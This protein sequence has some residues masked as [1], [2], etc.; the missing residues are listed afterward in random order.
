MHVKL[1]SSEIGNMYI[2]VN[3]SRY[4]Y[5]IRILYS[6]GRY[7]AYERGI[8]GFRDLFK[9]ITSRYGNFVIP[10]EVVSVKSGSPS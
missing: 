3:T 5:D 2:W 6:I 9:Q 7:L 8:E 10:P 1:I 4:L